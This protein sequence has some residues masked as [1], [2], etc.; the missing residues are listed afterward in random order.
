METLLLRLLR[1]SLWRSD[2]KFP[3]QLSEEEIKKL[4]ILAEEQTVTG[5][6]I[7]ALIKLQVK[8]PQQ[9][10]YEIIGRQTQIKNAN[11][12]LNDALK[13]L[14]ALP[15]GDFVVVK[16]QTIAALYPEP[17]VRMPGDI[18]FLVSDYHKAEDVINRCW[19]VRLPEK[20]VDKEFAFEYNNHLYEIH[21]KLVAFGSK[22]HQCYWDSLMK[23]PYD[24]MEIDGVKIPVLEST[25]NACYVFIHLFFH[26]V[27]AGVSLRQLCDW[28][29]VLHRHK[30]NIEGSQVTEILEGIGLKR[31]F[32]VLGYIVVEEL[33]LPFEEFPMDLM[34][35]FS[36]RVDIKEKW[37]KR[38][39]T[40]VFEGGSFGR[41]KHQASTG[42]IRKIESTG[43]AIRNSIKYYSLAPKEMRMMIPK[44]TKLNLKIIFS[45][46]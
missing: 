30:D 15:L 11:L 24:R 37:K 4:L 21:T 35:C 36:L 43:L 34:D 45:N 7:D 41:K 39:L 25:L 9:Y 46:T 19:R 13:K 16:G 12:D 31:A 40:D 17:L 3:E 33:G 27:T 26:L 5:L 1:Y 38:I 32:M 44:L 2:E 18:D 28:A 23:E 10:V 29:M 20:L 14:I 6:V 42:S 22:K 8:L